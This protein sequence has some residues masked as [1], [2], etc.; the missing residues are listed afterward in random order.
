MWP[1]V[2]PEVKQI[3]IS[4]LCEYFCCFNGTKVS[5]LTHLS[6]NNLV[7]RLKLIWLTHRAASSQ[8]GLQAWHTHRNTYRLLGLGLKYNC[9]KQE[10]TEIVVT[11]SSKINPNFGL[12]S[13]GR[14][15]RGENKYSCISTDR[16]HVAGKHCGW[17]C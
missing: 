3:C 4:A 15:S 17:K 12:F 1:H 10:M 5:T 7:P 13:R 11:S 8:I 6:V 2:Y 16:Y 14:S 9:K